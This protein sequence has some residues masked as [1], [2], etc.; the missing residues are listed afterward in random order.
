[1]FG[2]R[3]KGVDVVTITFNPTALFTVGVRLDF[4]GS[5]SIDWKDGSSIESLTSGVETTH[6]YVSAGTYVAEIAGDL[7]N[8]TLCYCDN[9]RVTN[10]DVSKFTSLETLF[11]Y[12]N[13]LTSLDVTANT[14]LIS[15]WCLTNAI[16]ALDLSNNVSLKTL[17]AA[18]NQLTTLDLSGNT[19]LTDVR[20]DNNNSLAVLNVS[21]NTVLAILYCESCSITSLNISSALS[22]KDLRCQGNGITATFVDNIYID[23][24]NNGVSNG[25]LRITLGN[26]SRTAA[27]DAANTSLLGKGWT[28][29]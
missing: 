12:G 3:G 24:D 13:L 11:C 10:L 23:L 5:I 29:T 16:T 4:T 14:A 18:T 8:V 25:V 17:Y 7:S 1:M 22:L 27:S 19:A 2:F 28:I 9:S 6:E 21:T 15:L 20:I 26:S